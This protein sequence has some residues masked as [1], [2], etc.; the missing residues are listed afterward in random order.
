MTT[1]EGCRYRL[2]TRIDGEMVG[3]AEADDALGVGLALVTIGEENRLAGLSAETI[4]VLDSHNH[5]W[6]TNP[7]WITRDMTP[8]H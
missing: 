5:R 6:L 4:G 7:G 1:W 3:V 2:Y 8:F